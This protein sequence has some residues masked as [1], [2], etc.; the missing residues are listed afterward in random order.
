M[1][2]AAYIEGGVSFQSVLGFRLFS[3]Q[4]FTL[5]RDGLEFTEILLTQPPL[6][7][8]KGVLMVSPCLAFRLQVKDNNKQLN[9]FEFPSG[10]SS[11]T[12]A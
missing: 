1:R 8:I 3:K 7:W 12:P 6:G 5:A 11:L 4:Y 2:Y 9:K 10:K